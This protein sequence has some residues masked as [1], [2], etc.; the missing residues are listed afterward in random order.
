MDV[1]QKEGLDEED[2][3]RLTKPKPGKKRKI[4]S[5]HHHHHGGSSGV[6]GAGGQIRSRHGS[7]MTHSVLESV[8]SVTQHSAGGGM[9][10][11]MTRTNSISLGSEYE[12]SYASE[13]H[14]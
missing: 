5:L 7:G 11:G 1:L 3:I 8:H 13:F 4:K 10:M 2:L 9:R 12:V 6:S 14:H